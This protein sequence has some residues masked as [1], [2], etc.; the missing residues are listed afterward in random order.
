MATDVA[1]RGLDIESLELVINYQ[2]SRDPE[3]HVHRIGRTGRAG[4]S[5]HAVSLV[6]EREDFKLTSVG[7]S[8]DAI[9]AL[10][11]ARHQTLAD[12]DW[13]TLQ[14]DG[15]KKQKLRPGDIVGALTRNDCLVFEQIGKI[16]VA[17][18]WAYVAVDRGVWKKALQQLDKGKLKGRSFRVRRVNL[19]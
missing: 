18:N 12:P 4:E 10:P 6:S 2:L 11:Q 1:A 15:G 7:A 13:V 5:G 14:L 8:A 19:G 17:D 9:E 3:V 16:A